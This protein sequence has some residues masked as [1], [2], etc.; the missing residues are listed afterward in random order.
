VTPADETVDEGHPVAVSLP[1]SNT[2][3]VTWQVA[4]SNGQSISGGS[5]ASFTFVP[6]NNGTYTV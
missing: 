1:A 3:S 5:G 4:A 6:N 2:Q